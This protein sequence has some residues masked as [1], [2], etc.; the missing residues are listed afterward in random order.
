MKVE[1]PELIAEAAWTAGDRSL[2]YH[3]SMSLLATEIPVKDYAEFR[4]GLLRVR[5]E[6]RQAVVL[7]RP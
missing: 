5:K 3:R 7:V 1:A 4:E 6:D 2:T